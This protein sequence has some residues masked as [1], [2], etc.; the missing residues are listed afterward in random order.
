MRKFLLLLTLLACTFIAKAQTARIITPAEV[1]MGNYATM[2]AYFQNDEFINRVEWWIK[3]PVGAA[4]K[5]TSSSTIGFNG[6]RFISSGKGQSITINLLQLGDYE[7]YADIFPGANT[8]G[9]RTTP[10]RTIRT[11]DCSIQE[12]LGSFVSSANFKETFGTFAAGEARRCITNPPAPAPPIIEYNCNTT[13]ALADDWY[14]VYWDTQV[15]GRTEWAASSDHTGDTRGGMLICNSS[16]TP[17]TFFRKEITGLCPGA[18]YNF[19]AWFQNLDGRQVL[20]NNCRSGYEYTGV[21]FIIEDL[22]TGTQLANFPT[23]D[24]SANLASTDKWVRFGGSIRLA[25]GQTSVVLKIR[26]DHP[27]GCGNDIAIDDIA[28]EYCAPKIFSYI[29]G[30]KSDRDAICQGAPIRLTSEIDPVNYFLNPLFQWQHFNNVTGVWDIVSGAGYT[31]ETTATLNIAAGVLNTVGTERFRLMIY[32]AGN[33]NAANCYTPGNNVE[34]TIL[35]KPV[36]SLSANRICRGSTVR[37]EVLSNPPGYDIY[38]FAGPA[39]IPLGGPNFS[40]I[41]ARP[42]ETSEYIVEAVANYGNGKTC[43]SYDTATVYVDTLPIVNLGPDVS[44]CI[45]TPITLDAG[46]HNAAF[47]I[48]WSG[49]TYSNYPGQTITVT[50][51]TN[52]YVTYTATVVNGGCNASD[53]INVTGVVAPTSRITTPSQNLCAATDVNIAAS[54]L[55]ANQQGAWTIVGNAY[56]AY[57]ETPTSLSTR[58]RSLP[59]DQTITVQWTSWSTVATGCQTVSQITIR[60]VSRPQTAVAGPTQTVCGTSSVTLAANAPLGNEYGTWTSSVAGVTFSDASNPAATM[61][62]SGALPRT[63]IVLTWTLRD[64][65]NVCT[66]SSS[67]VTI[68]MLAAPTLTVG[69]PIT[70]CVAGGNFT[71]TYAASSNAT[72]YSII[73]TGS[74]PMPGFVNITDQT[75]NNAATSM[76]VPYPATADSGT[77]T[78]RMTAAVANGSNTAPSTCSVSADFVLR[79]ERPSRID[80][81]SPSAATICTGSSIRLIA[82]GYK[83]PGA[84]FTWY[85]GSCGGT[86]VGT[87]DTINVSPTSSTVYYVSASAGTACAATPCMVVTVNVDQMPNKPNLTA[88]A[89]NCNNAAFNVT[90][91][92]AL[93]AGQTGSWTQVVGGTATIANPTSATTGVTVPVGTTA[94]LIWTVRQGACVGIPDTVDLTNLSPIT[95]NHIASNQVIC[96]GSSAATLVPDETIA[97]GTGTYTY[98]W[99][100]STTA[101]GVFMPVGVT[102]ATYNPG[103]ITTTYYYHRRATSAPCATVISNVIEVKVIRN[104]P[105]V[106]STP[107]A[108]TVNCVTGAD[109]TTEFGTPVFTHPDGVSMTIT[110]ADTTTTSGCNTLISRT[111]RAT[112]SCG[113]FVQTA[114]TLTVQDTTRPTFNLPLPVNA[115]AECG[116]IPAV[117]VVTATD[118]CSSATITY[119]QDT[120]RATSTCLNNYQLIRTWIAQDGCGN[121][122]SIKQIITVIDTTR[123][124]FNVAT[125]PADATVECTAIPAVATVTAT[126]VCNTAPVRMIYRQDTVRA[127]GACLNNYQLVRTWIARDTC[128]NM[129]SV[130]QTITV[131]DTTV[132]VFNPATVP[133][134]VTVEC[135]AIPG[136]AAVT[137]TD[138]CSTFPVRIDYRQDTVR[139]IGA[140]LNNYQLI[141]TWIATDTCGN[142]DSVKQTIT[143]VDTT[144][145]VFNPATVPANVTVECDA[146][147]GAATVTATDACSTY[148]VRIDYRQ[149]TVRTV[150]ACVSNYQLIRTWIATDTCGNADSVKQTITVVDTTV[151]VFNPATVPANVTVECDAIPGAATVTATDACSTYPVRIDYRQDTVR[152][153]GAC[154]SNYQLIRTWIATDTCGNADSVKQTITVVDTTV[155]V[156]NPATVPANVT[157][158]CDAIPGAATVTATD[159]C[160]TFPVTIT[161]RQDTV[162]AVGACLNNYQL[163]RTWIATDTCGNADSVKQTITVVDTTVPVFNPATV[164]ANVTVEC[165]AIPGAATVTATDA[166]STF[167]VTITY[168]QDTV[169][170]IGACLNNYQ[171]VRTWIATDTCGNADSVKQTITVVDTTVPVFNPATVPANVTVECDAIPGAAT[172]TATDACS[173]FPVTITYRQDT[174]RA[175]GACLNNYQLIRTWIATDTCG[176]ADSVKQTITVVDTTVPVFNPATVPANVTV[177]CDAIPGAATVNATDACSTFPV[178]ITYRQDTVR[179]VGVCLNNYQLIRTWIATDTC[180]NA[181]SVK[182]TITVVDTTVPVFNP[183]TVPANVTVECDAIPGAATVTATDACSTYPVTITYR[184]DTVRAVGA[185]LNNYQLVRTWIATDTCG[186]ADSVKQTITV[187]DTTVPVFNPATVPANVT[188]ECDAIPGAATVTATDACSTFPVTITYRQDTVRA[189]GACLNNYQLVR[190]WIATDTCGNADSVKQTITVVDTTVPVFNPATVPA[191]VTVEC[192]AIPGAATVTATDACSTFPVTIT[193]RQDTVRAIGA[194]LNNYQLVRTWIA[195][196]TC[197]NADSVKQTITVVD[198]TV[199]VFNPATVPANVTVECD[200]IPGAATVTATDACSTYPVRIDYR[201]DTVRT[202]GACLNNYQLIRTWIATDTCGNADSVKQTITVVDTT[203][204]V[205]NPAT[206]PAN[207]TVECDAIPG[208]ATVTATDACSTYPVRIDYRQDTV[209]TVG[210]CVSN[211][212]LIRTWIATDTCGNADSVK[213]TITVVDTTVPVFNPATVP[214]NVTVE[215]DAIPGAATVTATDACSTYPVRIDYRQDT[216]RTIGACLINYQLIRTWI[217]TDTCGNADSVKQTITVVDTTV[218][219]FDPATVPANV[220]VECDA[221]PGAATVTATDACSTFPVTITYRQDTVRAVGACLNNYQLVRTWIATDTCGNADSVKQT[222]TVV[223]TTVPVFDPATVPANVTVECDAIPGAATV[224]ATDACSTYPVRIDYRQDTVRAIGACLNNYQLIRTW[225]AT[226]TCG[227]ADSVK[228]IITVIDTT[229]PVFDPATVPADV[230]VECNVIPGAANVTATDACSQFPVRI[231]YRQDTSRTGAACVNNYQLIRTWIATDTCGNMDSVKQIITVI[232]TTRPVFDPA[233]VPAD[234]TVECTAI[235]GAA[236]VTATDACSQ[237]PV[238]IDYRQDTSRTTSTCINNYQLIRTWIATDTCGNMDSVKQIITVIDTTR[239]VFDPATVPADVTVECT[240]IPGA[241]TLTATDA[242]SIYPVRIDYRQ[243]TSRT[244]GACVNNYQ[245]IRT[246]IATDTCGNMDSVKQIITVIDTTRPV[247]DPATVPADAT[248]ECNAIPGAATVTATDA[249]SIYPVR[250]DYRQDTSRTGA[251]CANNYQLIRTWTAI[252]T[253]GNMDSVKQIITVIDTTRPV[254]NPA[255]VPADVT[256]ECNVIPGAANVTATDAC[257]QFPVRID[258]RQDTSRTGAACVNNYQLIR[259]WI[260][261]DT[262]GNMDS[263]KQIITVID[264]T[265]P[266]FDPATVPADATVEC[267]TIPAAAAVTATDACSQFPVRID[268][269]QDTARAAGACFNN[270]QLIRTW[271]ATDTCGNMDSVKQVLTVIDTTKPVFNMITVPAD[272]T[273]ECSALPS[274]P[275]VTATDACS[276]A[277]VTVTMTTR[278]DSVGS[279]SN[280]RITRTWYATDV[281]GNVDSIKQVITVMDTTRPVFVITAPADIAVSCDAIPTEPTLTASDNCTPVADIRITYV[282]TRVDGNCANSYSLI[283]TWT[284]F[285]ICGNSTSVQQ[286]ITV[287]DTTRPVFNLPAPANITVSCDSIPTAVTM[288][289]TDNCSPASAIQIIP[290]QSIQPIPGRCANNYLIVRTWTAIDECNNSTTITQTITVIDT[291]RPVFT[292]AI[293]AD[294]TVDCS[295]IPQLPDL[296]A[297]DNCSPVTRVTL[298]KNEQRVNIPG[299][300]RNN[301]QLIRTWTATDECSNIRSATQT[302]TVQDTTRPV[303]TTPAPA[304]VTVTCDSVPL[305]PDMSATDLCSPNAVTVTKNEQRVNTPG[306][307]VNNYQLLRTWTATDECGNTTTVQQ[308]ITVQ[309]MV[310]PRFVIAIPR[311]TTVNCDAIPTMPALAATDNCSPAANVTITRNEQRVDIAGA[312]DNNYRLLRTWTATDECGNYTTALQIITVQDTTRPVFTTPIPANATVDCGNVPAQPDLIAT[313]NCSAANRV[314]VTR[315]E[316]REEIANANCTGSYRL[317]RTW[318]AR[319]ECGNLTVATQILTVQDTTRPVFTSAP[320]RDTTVNCNEVPA[321]PV[322]TATDNCNPNGVTITIS[323]TKQFLSATCSNNYRLIRTWTA[324]DECGNTAIMQQILTVQDTIRPVFSIAPPRDTT[325]NCDAIPSKPTVTATDNCSVNSKVKVTQTEVRENIPNSCNYR[326]VRTWTAIDECG[327]SNIVRQVITVQDTTRPVIAPAPANITVTCQQPVPAAVVL[328]ATDNCDGTFPKNAVMTVDPF[329]ADIC[330]G[331][332]ITRRWNVTDACGNRAEE[333]VQVITIVPCPKPALRP[334]LPQNCSTNPFFTIETVNPVTRPTYILVGVT[335]SNAVRVPLSQTSNR[336]NLNGA[337]TASFIVRDGVTGCTSDTMTYQLNYIQTPVVNLGKDTSICGGDG[338][339]L[340][341]GATNFNNTIVWSTGATTQRI[342]VLQAGTYWVQVSNGI[343]V[344]RDTIKVALIPMPLIN[345]PDT[346]ICRGQSVRLNATVTGATYLW[347]TGATTPAINVSTQEQFWVRVMKNGCITIDT[348]NVTVNPPP[349]ITLRSDTTICPGQSVVLTVTSNAGRVQWVTG[350]TANSIAVNKAGNYW[351]AVTRDRCIVRDTV[352]VKMRSPLRFELGPDRIICPDGRFTIDARNNDAANYLWNDGDR[353]PIK[354]IDRAG[355]YILSILDRY[356]DNVISDSIRVRVAGAPKVSLGNDTM[357]CRGLTYT[358]KPKLLEDATHIRWS[359]GQTGPTLNVTEPGTYSVTAYNDCGS[360]TDEIIVDFMECESKPDIPNAFSPNGDGRN[361]VFRPVVRGPMYDYE[362]RI[363]NRWGEMIFISKDL[364]KGWDGKYKGKPVDNSTFVWW[365][366]YKKV[367]NGP[368]FILKGEVTVIR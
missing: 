73:A 364:H 348:V 219:V 185:C 186:N 175:V 333:R 298:T 161:Y 231:D 310:K 173:T 305:Q 104:T 340:D 174:V 144:V 290:G 270:Y 212:Q 1:C 204:P 102:T 313:D 16:E 128:G 285:D 112:D 207:V 86:V 38:N 355:T 366:S 248:V 25:A 334:T 155:P 280:Y 281:C 268:Y 251:A 243:D 274:A 74:N 166:C 296:Q 92:P 66:P 343:C 326:L 75:L 320:M 332:T 323:Q 299:A 218:P 22:A 183:A 117:P 162:R 107:P 235:P 242:C 167:P 41:D 163:V 275:V 87:G 328:R 291:T 169:R 31:G 177:E 259:T 230:T 357:I 156:F 344:T 189:V 77:Y 226:D 56:G 246:W 140:C 97:G 80:S 361:D 264:T 146:I 49:G 234:V 15:G 341:A 126:D 317:I 220:T 267:S 62:F 293:P 69:S 111:W 93:T 187:V 255:T 139:T 172:V 312:C 50:P 335:P 302:I 254:F 327:N 59:L 347:S 329:V 276:P 45:G 265:R 109:Y 79:V 13:T 55:S 165:D 258:Y 338:I 121:M 306:A 272:T 192:D 199:P 105:V 85:R 249:C 260:A 113:R 120:S 149:D 43:S 178:T 304:N 53:P 171:L 273:V 125:I 30:L 342:K 119:R 308:I 325:V 203:V 47:D 263:V 90:A 63:G 198:T 303:F 179:A 106:T 10:V 224:T 232:D 205:F 136:A 98:A 358:I 283:R 353:N 154:V 354:A 266:V 36:I 307:C 223:D 2:H 278:V 211:Y 331:Y 96:L 227:N 153:V 116:A 324:K 195:T 17:K 201:Q 54:S 286:T 279:C 114:Q 190:T 222:I 368:V 89:P 40:R 322:V 297:S 70:T 134:N 150:G 65:A 350:E 288:T 60:N 349:D 262:C 3:P 318:T 339:V 130:K 39:L 44:T 142:A 29:D 194:C 14:N 213:Q 94:S 256:V 188:V 352:Q 81:V 27:G 282:Q 118:E 252:D 103:A 245:L 217:A 294:T 363:F 345:L 148:P 238:R 209:R 18:V 26:N 336:F 24:V 35:E 91:S 157:V 83:S 346:T 225:I 365:M 261:T 309:D 51:V 151:P 180:G 244:A 170:A 314:T 95:N 168:R 21:T 76:A 239:P 37:L 208:A 295:A 145:P 367:Q 330:N 200:A 138:A 215:C 277:G 236:A 88:V 32:E 292:V 67:N 108:K 64:T 23:R 68:N 300:C 202:I 337:T 137:A 57:I 123:P 147:P 78:F 84:V 33:Q 58:V 197:G 28:F 158:E 34:L 271:I 182:Q 287:A 359:N 269:R 240:A 250:I 289:A 143:V 20:E 321:W 122:D 160:S 356:C 124:V 115:T 247:F 11:Y 82:Y 71:L 152:T 311:D 316:Q 127:A 135:D 100:R 9:R 184:Q 284:A 7:I 131:V 129:D 110:T 196:D 164:P 132:P 19:T 159:A 61:S 5:I 221:I 229:V 301:Y 319:D 12:C 133:A 360:T 362:L 233:T 52:G 181:D 214:A 206:V 6:L 101:T 4:F 257:S 193:Y 351:V 141:R 228:Q 253:C 315:N 191:N 48:R 216:V 241:A 42:L 210:A 46:S 72:R 237:F 99:F 176:N 8:S